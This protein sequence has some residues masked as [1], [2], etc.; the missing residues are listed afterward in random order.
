MRAQRGLA[1]RLWLLKALL[2]AAALLALGACEPQD[3]RPGLWLQG[4]AKPYPDDWSFTDEH[5]EIAIQ[6]AAPYFLP[7]SV[8]IVCGSHEGELI[9]GANRPETKNWPA[10]VDDD[11]NVVLKV[12]Q[13]LYE[14]RL[15]RINDP[16]MIANAVRAY[17]SKYGSSGSIPTSVRFWLVGPRV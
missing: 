13:N 9:V 8:T 2:A 5:M 16:L 14:A 3:R 7:H 10:W 11:P 12:G 4:E 17:A 15:T 6:V 1:P